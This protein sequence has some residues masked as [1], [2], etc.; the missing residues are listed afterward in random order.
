MF[1]NLF[2]IWLSEVPVGT[3]EVCALSGAVIKKKNKNKQVMIEKVIFRK[4][5]INYY[6]NYY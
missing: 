1:S 3:S 4:I 2:I 5:F 6:L